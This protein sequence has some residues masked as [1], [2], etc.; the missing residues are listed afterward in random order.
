[1]ED[2]MP[3]YLK[4]LAL[5]AAILGTVC[6][7]ASAAVTFSDGFFNDPSA[8]PPGVIFQTINGGTMGPWAVTGSI[9]LIGTYWNGP[10]IGGNS[11]DLN[12]I[13]QGAVSQTFHADAG[14]YNLGFYLSGNPDGQ[15]EQKHVAVSITPP[16]G[17]TAFTYLATLD[18][19]HNLNYEFHSLGFTSIG[20]DYT[21]TFASLDAGSYGG[22]LG[23]VTVS[24]VPEPSTWAMMILGFAGVGFIAYRRK[25]KPAL[26][27]V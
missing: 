7:Q 9:D 6:S 10:I 17:S 11:V 3:A 4:T 23:G 8:A 5:T 14:I 20:G 19:N 12:G 2:L 15:P 21:V 18:S 26:L 1:L 13:S 22:V 16:G 24:A 25:L 27:A